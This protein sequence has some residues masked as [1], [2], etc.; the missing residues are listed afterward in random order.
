MGFKVKIK[1]PR[2]KL[3]KLPKPRLPNPLDIVKGAVDAA[4]KVAEG[5]AKV[6]EDA[7]KQT[8]KALD[9]I[10]HL[11]QKTAA[12][13]ERA[14]KSLDK[15]RKKVERAV[16]KAVKDV[17]SAG[18]AA[19][20][21]AERQARAPLDIAKV[22]LHRKNVFDSLWY[23]ATEPLKSTSK[24]AFRAA[25]ESA[26]LAAAAQVAAT[27]YGGPAGAAA[28]SAW[29]AY[30]AS[31]GDLS[32]AMRVGATQGLISAATG[33]IST[34]PAP[35]QVAA[36]AALKA[37][38]AKAQGASTDDLKR[39]A[40]AELVSVA[41]SYAGTEN[42]GRIKG[43]MVTGAIHG[44][45]VAAGGG[46][47]EAVRR[48]MLSNGGAVLVQGLSDVAAK[49]KDKIKAE[50]EGFIA[51][52]FEG[53]AL[54]GVRKEFERAKD[55]KATVDQALALGR[56]AYSDVKATADQARTNLQADLDTQVKDLRS[57]IDAARATA[58]VARDAALRKAQEAQQALDKPT[59][60]I[61]AARDAAVK[62]GMD[63]AVAEQEAK[64]RLESLRQK[65]KEG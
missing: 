4:K 25:Q 15:E 33:A 37:A 44:A 3:P 41:T 10:A 56:N 61:L 50:G 31:G 27:A 40:L 48:A 19:A 39:Q 36:N 49:A 51:G 35:Q 57:K 53:D 62:A 18:E 59:K 28:Y 63:A 58:I 34:L 65:A 54:T 23:A 16:N 9:D 12:E 20:R 2:P 42:L 64:Q 32:L 22:A 13:L 38:V 6:A 46:D 1:L 60:D 26:I 8:A 29:M 7:I 14:A 24:N 11:P 30:Q 17:V 47:I 52:A 45:A 21:F 43:A 5:A 55:L